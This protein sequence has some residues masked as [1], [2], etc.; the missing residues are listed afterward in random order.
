MIAGLTL[1]AALLAAQAA[2]AAPP[3]E[4]A[5]RPTPWPPVLMF[6]DD[7]YPAHALRSGEEGV[8]RYRL[9]IGANGRVDGCTIVKSSGSE[10]L[11]NATCRIV[12]SRT[13]FSPARDQAG[14]AIADT[15]DG[16]VTWRLGPRN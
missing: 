9:D 6:S 10:A 12:R 1:A 2:P 13:R 16:E 7:D 4:A 5:P 8:V 3:A 15:R 14:N 11:D